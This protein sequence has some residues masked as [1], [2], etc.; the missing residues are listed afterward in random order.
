MVDGWENEWW[1]GNANTPRRVCPTTETLVTRLRRTRA[2]SRT[3]IK[4]FFFLFPLYIFSVLCISLKGTLRGTLRG[5]LTSS[6]GHSKGYSAG[7]SRGG[8]LR[9]TL[10]GTSR[11]T[12]G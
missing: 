10:R 12:P 7:R 8:I 4:T 2:D 1:G 11:G 9:G 5:T 3:K 6:K